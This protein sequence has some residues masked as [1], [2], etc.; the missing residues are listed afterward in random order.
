[1]T[2]YND[3][4]TLSDAEI[5]YLSTFLLWKLIKDIVVFFEYNAHWWNEISQ[6][7]DKV[8]QDVEDYEEFEK[9]VRL[10]LNKN[11]G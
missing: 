10:T 4:R 1:L 5:K 7:V 11:L 9:T 8:F 2:A 3:E 6:V